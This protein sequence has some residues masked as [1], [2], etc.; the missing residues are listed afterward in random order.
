MWFGNLS[1]WWCVLMVLSCGV[2]CG[3]VNGVRCGV[4]LCGEPGSDGREKREGHSGDDDENG[5]GASGARDGDEFESGACN[6]AHGAV[7][8]V[9]V[10]VAEVAHTL[11][12]TTAGETQAVC[13]VI[14]P[15]R[16]SARAPCVG[17]PGRCSVWWV[18]YRL[19]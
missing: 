6:G 7:L 1:L 5:D 16:E 11:V 17:S 10:C 8:C 2:L 15:K 18:F 13:S 3:C 19:W 12:S 9:A 14:V 4:L